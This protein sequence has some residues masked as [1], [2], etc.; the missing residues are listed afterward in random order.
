MDLRAVFQLENI[1]ICYWEMSVLLSFNLPNASLWN[2]PNLKSNRTFV[3]RYADAYI[4]ENSAEYFLQNINEYNSSWLHVVELFKFPNGKVFKFGCK[5]T[6]MA[7]S[8]QS[9]RFFV[10]N[11]FMNHG[12]LAIDVFHVVNYWLLRMLCNQWSCY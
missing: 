7:N 9:R 11:I 4:L 3:V 6:E 8:C 10:T 5:T 12:A 2:S 1:L